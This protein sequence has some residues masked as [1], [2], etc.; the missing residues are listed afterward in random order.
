[1]KAWQVPLWATYGVV[2]FFASIPAVQDSQHLALAATMAIRAMTGLGVS[3]VL[4]PVFSWR[5]K[6]GNVAW[7]ARVVATTLSA[8]AAWMI[9]DRIVLVTAAS[10]TRFSVPWSA[11]PRGMDLEYLFVMVAW[12]AGWIGLTLANDG[13]LQREELVRRTMEAQ[14]ARLELFAAQLNPHFLFNALNTIRSLAAED[15]ERTR[16]VVGRLSSFLRRVVS[17]AP[18]DPVPLSEEIDLVRDYLAIE[19]ARFEQTFSVDIAIANGAAAA[20]V[21]PLILQPLIENAV[22]YGDGVRAIC[23]RADLVG[24]S[25]TIRVENEGTLHGTKEGTGL[26]LTRSRL[27]AMYG[28]GQS[29]SIH[30]SNHTVVAT[31]IIKR[32]KT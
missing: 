2:H 23:I 19:E 31:V 21:P 16:E 24:E 30:Q 11:F 8:S 20:L 7:W 3:S 9:L 1:M 15:A 17:F 28:N 29:F 14:T 18:A 10:I 5:R 26:R 32:Q 12:S 4:L 6:Q 22:K 13:R 25:L 27:E